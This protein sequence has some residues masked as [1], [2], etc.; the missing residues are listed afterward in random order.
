M[1]AKKTRTNFLRLVGAAILLG[2]L[3]FLSGSS[4]LTKVRNVIITGL[5]PLMQ[6]IRNDKV[7]DAT[8][9][10]TKIKT[11]VFENEKLKEEN[12]RLK[13]VLDFGKTSKFS[14]SGA[15][16]LLYLKE[17][18]REYIII[19]A[20]ADKG[21]KEGD[22][23]IDSERILVGTVFEAGGGYSKILTASNP[24]VL[25]KAEIVPGNFSVISRGLGGR[26]LSI[27]L[28]PQ[29]APIRKGDFVV[30]TGKDAVA[31]N[32]DNRFYFLLGQ[33][34]DAGDNKNSLLKEARAILLARPENLNEVFVVRQ[35]P[36]L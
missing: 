31:E 7:L 18:D 8:S 14:V 28:L 3:I 30:A 26:S 15:D 35:I 1:A 2:A 9:D 13:R 23:V 36:E 22:W 16:V 19:N 10:D 25:F 6:L 11:L 20:G 21:I 27:E 29:D 5:K 33:I 17:F 32:A 12:A 34:V 24:D 4:A